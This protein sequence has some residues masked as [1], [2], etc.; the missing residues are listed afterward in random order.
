MGNVFIVFYRM[1]VI[2]GGNIAEKNSLRKA[3][4]LLQ[5]SCDYI[6]NIR[7]CIRVDSIAC[8]HFIIYNEKSR[9]ESVFISMTWRHGTTI[10]LFKYST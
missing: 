3:I 10:Y 5:L 6:D 8:N 2:D 9:L 1:E 7:I 4:V